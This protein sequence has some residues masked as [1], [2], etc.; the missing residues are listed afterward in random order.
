MKYKALICDVDGTHVPNH[1]GGTLSQKVIEA[2][3][4]AKD[5]I[6]VGIATARPYP[7]S[8]SLAEELALSG[9]SIIQSGGQIIDFSTNTLYRQHELTEEDTRN[10]QKVIKKFHIEEVGEDRNAFLSN[11]S[12]TKES[13]LAYYLPNLHPKK[14]DEVIM[15]FA[16]MVTIIAQKIPSWGH[17]GYIDISIGPAQA[18]K[19]HG[20]LEVAKILGIST[21][22]IIGIGDGYNDFPL[23][24][25]CGLKVAIGNAVEDL[26][27]IADY[28][29]PTVEEDGVVD[30]IEKLV[31]Q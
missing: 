27:A 19:Q 4:R 10:I 24:M 20:I 18:T 9:P 12:V 6:H 26:K 15:G 11:E 5:V 17:L 28:V 8:L 21:H 30:V 3:A 7:D 22:E 1:A 13:I 31:L 2:I 29:A 14:A 25:A 16:D 23:L